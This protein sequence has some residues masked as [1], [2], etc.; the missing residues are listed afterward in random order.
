MITGKRVLVIEDGPTVTHGEMKYGAGTIAAQQHKAKEVIDPRPF[1]VGSIKKTFEKYQ[2]LSKVLP[3]MGYGKEQIR[4]LEETIH[5]CDCDVVI[6]G[7]PIDLR[8]VLSVEKPLVRVRYG[9]G[10]QTKHQL[11]QLV[12][13]FLH[14]VK[15]LQ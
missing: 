15:L 1:A 8:R 2:H 9:V 3:A 10:E 14:Q 12:Q 5:R 6:S 11:E 7:T 4:E 13:E